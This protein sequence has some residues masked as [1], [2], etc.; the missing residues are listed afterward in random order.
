LADA[1]GTAIAHLADVTVPQRV[2]AMAGAAVAALGRLDILVNNVGPPSSGP[3]TEIS[4]DD[5]RH[6][7]ATKLDSA[8]LHQGLGSPSDRTRARRDHQYRRVFGPCRH[9]QR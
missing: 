6:I 7:M 8:F 3:V 1:G 9:R 5:W 2:E 4:Y